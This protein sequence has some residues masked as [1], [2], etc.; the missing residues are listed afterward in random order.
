MPVVRRADDRRARY[1]PDDAPG[2]RARGAAAGHIFVCGWTGGGRSIPGAARLMR[3][4]DDDC[5]TGTRACELGRRWRSFQRRWREREVVSMNASQ[6]IW[7]HDI[8]PTHGIGG[9]IPAAV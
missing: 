7:V 1:R 9:V 3:D 4:H 2:R 8:D 5:A 6:E